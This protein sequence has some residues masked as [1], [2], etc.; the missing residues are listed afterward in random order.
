MN[1]LPKSTEIDHFEASLEDVLDD[2]NK[3]LE[4]SDSI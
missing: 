1:T 4:V 3:V 2:Y